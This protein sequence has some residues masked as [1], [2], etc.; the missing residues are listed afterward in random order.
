MNIGGALMFLVTMLSFVAAGLCLL[1]LTS[2]ILRRR[3]GQGRRTPA[4]R[5]GNPANTARSPG[6]RPEPANDSEIS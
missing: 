2:P 3:P 6:R 4:R 5:G 1:T